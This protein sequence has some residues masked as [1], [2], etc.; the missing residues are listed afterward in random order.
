MQGLATGVAVSGIGAGMIDLNKEWGAKA[1][2]PAF[3]T[4]TGGI[5]AGLLVQYLPP[6]RRVTP[7]SA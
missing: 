6:P 1:V 2:A 3:G 4:A 5:L 7:C